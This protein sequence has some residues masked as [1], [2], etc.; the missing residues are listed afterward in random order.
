MTD[1]AHALGASGVYSASSAMAYLNDV[2]Q[3]AEVH[4]P[5]AQRILRT[6][7]QF[8][9]PVYLVTMKG[10]FAS[11]DPLPEPGGAIFMNMDASY[12]VRH[13]GAHNPD[14]PFSPLHH[15]VAFLHE[16]G[17]A[18]QKI[19]SPAAFNNECKGPR[20]GLHHA[21][22]DAAR[23]Y[24]ERNHS[25]QPF[26]KRREWFQSNGRVTPQTWSVRLEYD[27][28]YRHERPIC[29]EAGLPARDFYSDI[30]TH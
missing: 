14:A 18:V 1:I 27:N 13:G 17:H 23:A 7:D 28:I 12:K 15:F 19:E 9:A 5:T 3:W 26:S 29:E 8:H 10:G 11:Y 24:G 16:C 4:S 22:A 2:R 30:A 20:A 6:I 21:I 25:H